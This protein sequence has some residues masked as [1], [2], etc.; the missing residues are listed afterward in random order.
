MNL[1]KALIG[2]ALTLA[3]TGS[4]YLFNTF[5]RKPVAPIPREKALAY[6]K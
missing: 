5:L 4:Y 6:I 2:G 1:N 3:L